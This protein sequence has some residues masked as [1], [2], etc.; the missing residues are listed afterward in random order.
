MGPELDS[1][2]EAKARWQA[3]P[4]KVCTS[5]KGAVRGLVPSPFAHM[6][7]EK[8]DGNI[9]RFGN[10]GDGGWNVCMDPGLQKPE[11]PERSSALSKVWSAMFGATRC[12]AYLIG[13]GSDITFDIEFAMAT[14]CNVY[15]IDPTPGLAQR[16]ESRSGIASMVLKRPKLAKEIIQ[17]GPPPNWRHVNVGVNGADT[18]VHWGTGAGW[19]SSHAK[20]LKAVFNVTHVDTTVRLKSIPS[21]MRS[22]GHSSIQLIK[23]DA[24]GAEWQLLNDL[25]TRTKLSQL[26]L[27]MHGITADK[28]FAAYELMMRNGFTLV[29]QD[30][31]RYMNG[32]GKVDKWFAANGKKLVKAGLKHKPPFRFQHYR[33]ANTSSFCGAVLGEFHFYR[34]PDAPIA[35]VAWKYTSTKYQYKNE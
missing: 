25:I 4:N 10:S 8:C 34:R 1:F 29:G 24:E 5:V 20:W 30:P 26:M 3:R 35:P 19:A 22:L 14:K 17:G 11:L 32:G 21:L 15:T 27:E 6:E 12:A 2:E 31:S 33:Y 9:V 16:L 23:I 7:P 13:A 28:L 18:T